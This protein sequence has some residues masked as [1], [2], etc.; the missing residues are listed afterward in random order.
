[1]LAPIEAL[2]NEVYEFTWWGRGDLNPG[3]RGLQ[4]YV[5]DY[6]VNIITDMPHKHT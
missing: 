1:M 3:P 6:L 4:R 5:R 2:R